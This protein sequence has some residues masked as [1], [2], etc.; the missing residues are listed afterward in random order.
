[1]S[2][3]NAINTGLFCLAALFALPSCMPSATAS[4]ET[5]VEGDDPGECSDGADNDL[6]GYFDCDDNGCWGSPDCEGSSTNTNTNT[7]TNTGTTTTTTT[8]TTTSTTTTSTGP[9][10]IAGHLKAFTLTYS[11]T[12]DFGKAA[13]IDL[14]E[15]YDICDCVS[16]Y[17]ADSTGQH[18]AEGDRVTFAGS[19]GMTSSDCADGLDSVWW[20]NT[21]SEAYASF[22]F[23]E[24]MSQLISWFQH[25]SPNDWEPWENAFD[26]EQWYITDMYEDFDGASSHYEELESTLVDG[27]IPLD[28]THVFDVTFTE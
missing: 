24:D 27:L 13:G 10:A 21:T 9:V 8:T 23:E 5:E 3:M 20:N 4:V 7:N 28:L 1:M 19:W 15:L 12:M 22:I 2:R 14:C 16:E 17:S 11:L 26:H 18:E 25:D 6:D